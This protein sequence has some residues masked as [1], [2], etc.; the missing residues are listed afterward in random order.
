MFQRNINYAELT[1]AT[2]G[3]DEIKRKNSFPLKCRNLPFDVLKLTIH[4]IASEAIDQI[5][6]IK[7]NFK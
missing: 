5:K 1:S 7:A 3:F 6:D 2:E 4:L